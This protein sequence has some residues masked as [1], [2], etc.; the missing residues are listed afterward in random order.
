MEKRTG[1]Q[2][3]TNLVNEDSDRGHRGNWGSS[4]LAGVERKG[5]LGLPG[6]AASRVKPLKVQCVRS[7]P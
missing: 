3:E 4:V 7:D 5:V 1:T 2:A 6:G